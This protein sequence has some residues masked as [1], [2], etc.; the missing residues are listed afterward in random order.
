MKYLQT[1]N[2]RLKADTYMSAA[3]KL[4]NKHPERAERLEKHALNNTFN[5]TFNLIKPVQGY[6]KG[7]SQSSINE[8]NIGKYKLKYFGMEYDM[9][10]DNIDDGSDFNLQFFAYF[11][12]EPE[13]KKFKTIKN[14]RTGSISEY[15]EHETKNMN[16]I[17]NYN[18][19]K[20]EKAV[21]EFWEDEDK[22]LFADRE[23][24]VKFK[25]TLNKW[26]NTTRERY[27]SEEVFTFRETL[28]RQLDDLSKK[29]PNFQFDDNDFDDLLDSIQLKH[30]SNNELY[31]TRRDNY[32]L[33][34]VI[35]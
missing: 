15:N 22:F 16:I 5:E 35:E 29:A 20:F 32:K 17:V 19:G 25:K 11:H 4:K 3:S 10:L 26:I 6:T 8:V 12:E 28:Y 23:S 7:L 18:S 34:D 1:F 24:V 31:L 30:I 33:P 13:T 2:E 9:V 27:N 21:I 14:Q